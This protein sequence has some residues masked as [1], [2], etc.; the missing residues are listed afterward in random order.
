MKGL[1]RKSG[2]AL[3]FR[4]LRSINSTRAK[5]QEGYT[6]LL[7]LRVELGDDHVQRCLANCVQGS[8]PELV[9]VHQ[10]SVGVTAGDGDDLLGGTV[11]DQGHK[12][13]EEVDLGR[14]INFE[15]LVHVF[16]QFLGR[17]LSA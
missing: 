9:L 13:G 3:T 14:G 6:V 11:E 5:R 10:V 8:V 1:D 7:V 15:K 2:S 17:V 4:R 16:V 12:E